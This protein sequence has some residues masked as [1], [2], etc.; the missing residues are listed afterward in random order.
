MGFPQA[1]KEPPYWPVSLH[2]PSLHHG[3]DSRRTWPFR[4][5]ESGML[6]LLLL[7]E[8]FV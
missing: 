6:T 4:A 7:D 1:I 8:N 5:H 2:I 3:G